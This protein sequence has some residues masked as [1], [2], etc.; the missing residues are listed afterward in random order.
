MDKVEA[1]PNE[2]DEH[3]ENVPNLGKLAFKIFYKELL[4]QATHDHINSV[5]DLIDNHLVGT[6]I[7]IL[8]MKI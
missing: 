1:I 4:C 8:G 6:V 3:F 5:R 7:K 2:G